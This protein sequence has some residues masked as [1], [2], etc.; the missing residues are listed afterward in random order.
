ME[1]LQPTEKK[2]LLDLGA[3]PAEVEEYEALLAA[4]FNEDPDLGPA[5]GPTRKTIDPRQRRLEELTQKL[6]PNGIK[7]G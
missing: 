2:G 6:F 7:Q 5:G 1:P 3:D 4:R